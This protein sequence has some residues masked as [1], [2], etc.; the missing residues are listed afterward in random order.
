[1]D[2][3]Y[4][5]EGYDQ[6]LSPPPKADFHDFRGEGGREGGRE[7]RM[8]GGSDSCRMEVAREWRDRK[9][10]WQGMENESG[11]DCQEGN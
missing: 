8:E 5:G 11:Q 3:K 10:N 7:G 6:C 2:S 1:M 9:M 4:F